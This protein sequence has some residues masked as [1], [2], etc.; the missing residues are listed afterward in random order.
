LSLIFNSVFQINEDNQKIIQRFIPYRVFEWKWGIDSLKHQIIT[1]IIIS[2]QIL[3]PNIQAHN[4]SDL[5]SHW[6]TPATKRAGTYCIRQNPHTLMQLFA[7]ECRC[8]M[9]G[10]FTRWWQGGFTAKQVVME[11]YPYQ[12]SQQNMFLS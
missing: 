9:W 3:P 5:S 11:K 2:L 8:W 6:T 4:R 7:N 12:I 1:F 10:V